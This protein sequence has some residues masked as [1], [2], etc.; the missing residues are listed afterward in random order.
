[1]GEGVLPQYGGP[2]EWGVPLVGVGGHSTFGTLCE[3]VAL[4]K[5]STEVAGNRRIWGQ[6]GLV[7]CRV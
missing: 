2:R 5:S 4:F 6:V 1:M 7:A 3:F